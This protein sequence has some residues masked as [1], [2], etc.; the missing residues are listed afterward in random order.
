MTTLTTSAPIDTPTEPRSLHRFTGRA[1]LV[2]GLWFLLQPV[3]VAVDST[4]SGAPEDE[5]LTPDAIASAVWRGPLEA[6]V[7]AGV[8]VALLATVIGVDRLVDR[9]ESPC[10]RLSHVLG[11]VAGTGWLLMAGLSIGQYSSVAR[12]MDDIGADTVTMQTSMHMGFVITAGV[13]G[14]TATCLAGW[15]VGV[16]RVGLRSGLIGAPASVV[17]LV[18]AA[19]CIVPQLVWSQPFG[20]MATAPVLVVLGAAILRR[21]R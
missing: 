13:L 10:W 6:V 7:F 19:V 8:G 14:L 18:G 11:L 2:C 5:W 1:A 21:A 15:L 16:A 12:A 20:V 4:S 3:L 17:A 9:R